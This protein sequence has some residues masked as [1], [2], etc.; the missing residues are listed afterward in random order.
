MLSAGQAESVRE[1]V[2][3]VTAQRDSLRVRTGVVE[4]VSGRLSPTWSHHLG[5][6]RVP[7]LLAFFPLLSLTPPPGLGPVQS[8][9]C[10][11]A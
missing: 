1:R 9:C 7:V 3:L 6:T 4:L 11:Y 5:V 2:I 8:L 10:V